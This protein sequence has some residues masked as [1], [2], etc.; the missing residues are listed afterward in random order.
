VQRVHNIL[1]WTDC[2]VGNDNLKNIYP[3][4]FSNSVLKEGFVDKY[5]V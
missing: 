1:F 4:F 2:W 5:G 3:I